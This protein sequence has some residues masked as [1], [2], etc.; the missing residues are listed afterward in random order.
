MRESNIPEE[1]L[2]NPSKSALIAIVYLKM[3]IFILG[4]SVPPFLGKD[5]QPV[6][7]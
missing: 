1:F 5:Q 4:I 6:A 2:E 7:V 3:P